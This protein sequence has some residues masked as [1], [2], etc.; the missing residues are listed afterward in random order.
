MEMRIDRMRNHIEA[1][2]ELLNDWLHLHEQGRPV[3]DDLVSTTSEA[4]KT[5]EA[6]RYE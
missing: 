5:A 6:L 3:P 1:M 2:Q 4:I